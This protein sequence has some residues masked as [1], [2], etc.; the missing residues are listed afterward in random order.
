MR[1]TARLLS[2]FLILSL[3]IGCAKRKN[4]EVI[5]T[6]IIPV[7]ETQEGI[8]ESMTKSEESKSVEEKKEDK[9]VLEEKNKE[10]LVQE[11]V[12]LKLGDKGEKVLEL[13]KKLYSIGY[14]LSV[15]S[16]FGSK[17][18]SILSNFQKEKKITV[19]GSLTKTA[20]AMLSKTPDKR[21]YAPPQVAESK[22]K[23]S[24]ESKKTEETSKKKTEQAAKVPTTTPPRE[25]NSIPNIKTSPGSSQQVV[26]VLADSYGTEYAK[27]YAYE[28][29][30]GNWNEFSSGS[31]VIGLR[32]FNKNKREGDLATPVGKYSF[33]FMFGRKPNPGVNFTYR[34]VNTN[35]YWVSSNNLS[36]YNVW[37]HYDGSDAKERLQNY[38]KLWEQ[39]LYDY[40]ALIDYNYYNGS[41]VM[42]K[43]S[44]IFLHI[45]PYGGRGTEGCIGLK[46]DNLLKVMKWLNPSKKPVIIMGVKGDI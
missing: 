44:G 21:K 37:K 23:T 26:V 46:T 1:N 41:K 25:N 9:L 3:F 19:T 39:P 2:L 30:N 28:K 18:A 31:A 15:D 36:E 5:G 42:N 38:E 20:E 11:E 43:G 34:K 10:K 24:S 17:T 4:L 35:D 22:P 29:V 45:A 32:G 7:E 8:D 40:A 12:I 27:Y 16:F 33:P 13:Q 6:N 14:D